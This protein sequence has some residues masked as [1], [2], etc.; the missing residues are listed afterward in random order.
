MDFM[1]EWI[2][3]RNEDEG[4]MTVRWG[5]GEVYVSNLCLIAVK[6]FGVHDWRNKMQEGVGRR[7]IGAAVRHRMHILSTKARARHFVTD[8]ERYWKTR[9]GAS[10]PM[11][12]M[13]SVAYCSAYMAC[14]YI[15]LRKICIVRKWV[16][17]VSILMTATTL[18]R[19]ISWFL[20]IC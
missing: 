1:T 3:Q 19:R 11:V 13:Q 14:T 17:Y 16:I 12:C 20:K 6:W 9:N 2:Y 10:K 8:V 4:H 5:R 7:D 18:P 15:C